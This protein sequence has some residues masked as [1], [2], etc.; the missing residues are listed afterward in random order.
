MGKYWAIMLMARLSV[1]IA[2]L[3]VVVA[4][5]FVVFTVG[6]LVTAMMPQGGNLGPLAVLVGAGALLTNAIITVML[7]FGAL[8]WLVF[9]QMLLVLLEVTENTRHL[10]K[11]PG[12]IKNGPE[13]VTEPPW[14]RRGYSDDD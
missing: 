5:L 9:G 7:L 14:A 1:I 10:R 6:S 13:A 11:L 4:C 2:G 3:F 12:A 8:T